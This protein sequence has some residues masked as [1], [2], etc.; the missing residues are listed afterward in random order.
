M[1]EWVGARWHR[2]IW[3]AADAS[4]PKAAVR[5]EDVQ[6]AVQMLF[7]AGGGDAIVR[8]VPATAQKV[9]GPRGWLHRIRRVTQPTPADLDA[10]AIAA[11]VPCGPTQ[12]ISVR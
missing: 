9:G 7:R 8:V 10:D 12:L 4:F 3:Q 5:L 2:F 11:P 6:R 1:E